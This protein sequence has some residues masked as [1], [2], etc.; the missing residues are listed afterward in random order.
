MW[1]QLKI[2]DFFRIQ[3]SYEKKKNGGSTILMRNRKIKSSMD[4]YSKSRE[5]DMSIVR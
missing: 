5:E 4:S 1:T 2:N 3:R